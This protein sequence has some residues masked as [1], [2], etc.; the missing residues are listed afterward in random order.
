M[1][2]PRLHRDQGLGMWSVSAYVE[3]IVSGLAGILIWLGLS[4]TGL[5]AI[6]AESSS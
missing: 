6:L 3:A 4:V 2:A 5:L 1:S